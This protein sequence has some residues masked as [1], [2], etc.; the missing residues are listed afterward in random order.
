MNTMAPLRIATQAR[1]QPSQAVSAGIAVAAAPA[2]SAT[3]AVTAGTA[4]ARRVFRVRLSAGPAAAAHARREVRAAILSWKI[5]VDT[6]VAILLTSE[7]VSNVVA[8]TGS[9]GTLAVT[10]TDSHLRVDVYDA[11]ESLPMIVD[12]PADAESGR[13][14]LLVD[15][16]ATGWGF[17]RTPAGKAVFFTVAFSGLAP[18]AGAGRP[19][20]SAHGDGAL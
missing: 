13:G 5:P 11:S 18:G 4:G 3:A 20:G 17:Y 14:L 9:R 16:L 6:D 15:V 19:Q 2:T 1:R 7:L 8:H 12:A 10:C